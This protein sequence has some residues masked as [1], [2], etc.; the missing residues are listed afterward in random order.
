MAARAQA[1]LRQALKLDA[2]ERAELIDA[3]LRSFDDAA[4]GPFD[5]A[6]A[7]EAESRIDAHDA[8]AMGSVTANSVFRRLG[9]R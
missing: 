8:G 1:V 4:A 2:I 5:T 3:L 9:K 6:W 7:Q